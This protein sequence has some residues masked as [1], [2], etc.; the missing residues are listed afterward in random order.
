METWT[1][2]CSGGYGVGGREKWKR[3][4]KELLHQ[5]EMEFKIVLKTDQKTV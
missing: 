5:S 3:D 4:G 2:V 1:V